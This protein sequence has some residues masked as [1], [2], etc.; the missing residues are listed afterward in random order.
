[1]TTTSETYTP[2]KYLSDKEQARLWLLRDEIELLTSNIRRIT[3][4][5]ETLQQEIKRITTPTP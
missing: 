2:E 1:M 4:K 5:R 3:E